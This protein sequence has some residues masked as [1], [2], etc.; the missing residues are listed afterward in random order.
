MLRL[1]IGRQFRRGDPP[2][3]LFDSHDFND[4]F[5]DFYFCFNCP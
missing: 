3:V 1:D 4:T 2:P 5:V